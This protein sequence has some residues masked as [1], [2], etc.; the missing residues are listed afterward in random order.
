MSNGLERI[1]EPGPEVT[2]KI[3]ALEQWA[4]RLVVRNANDYVGVVETLK[5]VKASRDDVTGF[6]QGTKE[7][8]GIKAKAYSTWQAIC[9]FEG[10]FVKRLDAVR[11]RGEKIALAWKREDEERTRA[12][13]RRLQAIAD[14]QARKEREKLEARAEKAEEKGKEEKAEALREQAAEIVAPVVQVAPST[15]KV[16]GTSVRKIWKARVIDVTLVPRQ[17]LMVNEKALDAYAK[18][19]NGTQQVLGV[20]FYEEAS[21]A[22]GGIR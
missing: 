15:P 5:V 4:G 20:Q 11:E 10:K 6:F 13:Q 21:L 12:E 8:P 7:N 2:G 19:T 3:Q 16:A 1:S 18:A 17:F 14:E 22:V 9:E